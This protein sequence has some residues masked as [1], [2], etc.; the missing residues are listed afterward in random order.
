MDTST[1]LLT[2]A[3]LTYDWAHGKRGASGGG[4]GVANTTIR[5]VNGPTARWATAVDGNA[6]FSAAG[7][8]P[9]LAILTDGAAGPARKEPAEALGV[10]AGQVG[11][12]ARELLTAMDRM[13]GLDTAPGL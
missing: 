8:W 1:V 10:P 6:V 5:A 9:L 11:G 12:A 4:T 2:D 7:V 3:E 13:R